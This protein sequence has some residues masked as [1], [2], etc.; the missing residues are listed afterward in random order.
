VEVRPKASEDPTANVDTPGPP[1]LG[2]GQL[3]GADDPVF[4]KA[5]ELLKGSDARKAA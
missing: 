3:P 5:L 4:D 1:P 2:P